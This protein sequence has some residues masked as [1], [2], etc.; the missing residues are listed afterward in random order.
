MD[1]PDHAKCG[2]CG[3]EFERN[4][5]GWLTPIDAG[6]LPKGTKKIKHCPE[7]TGQEAA[8]IH[9]LETDNYG[10]MKI[11]TGPT[12]DIGTW[13]ELLAYNE[14]NSWWVAGDC[15]F[16]VYRY[17]QEIEEEYALLLLK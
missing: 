11:A 1:K 7:C 5:D 10:Y 14:L 2:K 6:T 16:G 3:A 17:E 13:N 9:F 15:S 4:E 12:W 8:D